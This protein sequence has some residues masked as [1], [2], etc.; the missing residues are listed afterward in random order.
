M[1][2]K[3]VSVVPPSPPPYAYWQTLLFGSLRCSLGT[4]GLTGSHFTAD[5]SLNC[6]S[7]LCEV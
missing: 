7:W 2:S 4:S 6:G 1:I 5:L 3:L